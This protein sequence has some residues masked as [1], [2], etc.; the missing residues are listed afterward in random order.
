MDSIRL[1]SSYYFFSDTKIETLQG[2]EFQGS[3][4]PQSEEIRLE[5]HIICETL[6]PNILVCRASNN[7]RV[8]MRI[9]GNHLSI[10]LGPSFRWWKINGTVF[11]RGNE[12]GIMWSDGSEW[13]KKGNISL[14]SKISIRTMIYMIED[15]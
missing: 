3:W 12:I 6:P 5:E 2:H 8:K 13:I 4:A 7:D 15:L 1:I 9:H 11:K 14:E 10:D